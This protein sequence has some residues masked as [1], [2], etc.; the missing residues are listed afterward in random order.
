V[1]QL[2]DFVDRA[3]AANE[4]GDSSCSNAE[5][6]GNAVPRL[7]CSAGGH[8]CL[9]TGSHDFILHLFGFTHQYISASLAQL[10]IESEKING[11]AH[12]SL[13]QN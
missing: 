13:G 6:R 4:K 9:T 5:Q 7:Q 8:T 10:I 11:N 1:P 3:E 2:D 12:S